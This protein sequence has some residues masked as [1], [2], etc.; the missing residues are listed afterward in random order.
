LKR[1]LLFVILAWL[2]FWVGHIV[3]G[4]L[5]WRFMAVGPLNA[6]AATMG[7]LLFLFLGEWLGRIEVTHS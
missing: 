6:G 1:L 4:L 3:G 7:S 2:G 5:N